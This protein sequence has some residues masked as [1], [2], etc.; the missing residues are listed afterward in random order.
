M[1]CPYCGEELETSM[2][3]RTEI[4]MDNTLRIKS[5]PYSLNGSFHVENQWIHSAFIV[6]EAI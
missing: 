3:R 4:R 6:S 2:R 5:T 1:K